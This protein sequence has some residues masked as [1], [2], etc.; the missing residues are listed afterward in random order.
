MSLLGKCWPKGCIMLPMAVSDLRCPVGGLVS[1]SDASESGGGLCVSHQLT[2]ERRKQTC[3][4]CKARVMLPRGLCPSGLQVRCRQRSPRAQRFLSCPFSME[5]L[6]SCAH[7]LV[8]HMPGGRWVLP[9]PKLMSNVSVWSE[10][11]GQESS[12][13]EKWRMWRTRSSCP[14]WSPWLCHPVDSCRNPCQGLEGSRSK[15]FFETPS[16]HRLCKNQFPGKV[17]LMMENVYSMMSESRSEFASVLDVRPVLVMASDFPCVCRPTFLGRLEYIP[18]G[19]AGGRRVL[20][21]VEVPWCAS[22]S[23]A[24]GGTSLD[25]LRNRIFA[26]LDKSVAASSTTLTASGHCCSLQH[27]H[28]R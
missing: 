27:L 14:W 12:N 15:L 23:C 20:P 21:Q 6:Q 4:P 1:A 13:L 8:C 7:W 5:L 2:D 28:K 10:K 19:R 26:D 25:S 16:S 3:C 18:P 17:A 9:Q 11:D 22:P 24:L